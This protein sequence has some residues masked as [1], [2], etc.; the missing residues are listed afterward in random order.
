MIFYCLFLR[1]FRDHALRDGPLEHM[2]LLLKP[3]REYTKR[4][5][6]FIDVRKCVCDF[7]ACL[8]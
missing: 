8:G 6:E 4:I 2:S 3:T 5:L 1:S 7:Q